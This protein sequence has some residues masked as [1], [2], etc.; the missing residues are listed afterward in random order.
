[1]GK[2]DTWP[3]YA[4]GPDSAWGLCLKSFLR[5]V[6]EKSGSKH[7]LEHYRHDLVL[8]FTTEPV[9]MPDQYTRARVEDFIY[10]P[11]QANGRKSKAVGAGTINNRLSAISSFYTYAAGYGIQNGSGEITPLMSRMSPTA[12]I[13]RLQRNLRYR[14]ISFTDFERLFSVIPTDAMGLRDRAILLFLFWTAARRAV[15]SNLRWGDLYQTTVI[16]NGTQRDV[17][18]YTFSRKGFSRQKDHAELPQRAK[19]ALDTY[20]IAVGRMGHMEPDDA[21]FTAL[22]GY[23]GQGGYDPK[24]PIAPVTI[25]H[26]LKRYIKKANLDPKITIHSLRH[27]AAQQRYLAGSGIKD[28]QKLL[29]HRSLATTDVYLTGLMGT[30]DPGASLLDDKFGKF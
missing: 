27:M 15:V 26:I 11:G 28:I 23:I 7:S 3:P 30:S 2:S 13:Q 14:T 20:L 24:R 18:M 6:Y 1:M 21:L 8:F 29:R 16:E 10:S 5:R 4:F 25:W 12:G 22:P 17:W 9:L 19:D